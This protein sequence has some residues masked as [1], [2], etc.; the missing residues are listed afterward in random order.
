MFAGHDMLTMLINS[1]SKFRRT[2][3]LNTNT[4]AVVPPYQYL[5]LARPTAENLQQ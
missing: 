2:L 1:N 3:L 5:L 4:T